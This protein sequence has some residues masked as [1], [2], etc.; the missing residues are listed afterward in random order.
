MNAVPSANLVGITGIA[1]R[2]VM[3]G[4][5]EEAVARNAMS[6]ASEA[7]VPLAQWVNDKKLVSAP[8]M[9][10]ANAIE[11][12]RVGTRGAHHSPTRSGLLS[13]PES[14]MQCRAICLGVCLA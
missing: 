14:L 10:A 8:Q 5:M 6:Q 11:P 13:P 4:A 9:A 3:D 7:K 12:R 2:L 1:R